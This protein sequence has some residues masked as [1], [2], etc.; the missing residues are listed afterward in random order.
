MSRTL[1]N[2]DEQ[3]KAWLAARAKS[4]RVSMNEIVRRAVDRFRA[5]TERTQ[6]LTQGLQHTAGIWKH[7]DGL[8]W[9][10]QLRDEWEGR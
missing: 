1:I 2:L 8:D 6:A 10:N 5:D 3:S 7:G 9:Q 4:E